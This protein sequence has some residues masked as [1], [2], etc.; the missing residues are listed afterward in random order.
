MRGTL[1][2]EKVCALAVTSVE[3]PVP[4]RAELAGVIATAGATVVPES[5]AAVAAAEP[6]PGVPHTCPAVCQT[7][8]CY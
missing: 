7:P 2:V 1:S 8:Y 6:A 5:A 3:V 4:A